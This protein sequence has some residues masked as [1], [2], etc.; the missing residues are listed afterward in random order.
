MW[1]SWITYEEVAKRVVYGSDQVE[2][3]LSTDAELVNTKRTEW[4][5]RWNR[6]VER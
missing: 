1:G 4:T 6:S 3:L 2:A 5:T